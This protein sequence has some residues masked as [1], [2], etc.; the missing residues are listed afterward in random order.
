M[1]FMNLLSVPL[2]C[3]LELDVYMSVHL[4]L[5]DRCCTS[6]RISQEKVVDFGVD[7]VVQGSNI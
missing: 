2:H 1:H 3:H 6:G 5:I 7:S 4:F